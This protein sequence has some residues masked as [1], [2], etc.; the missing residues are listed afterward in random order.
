[1]NNQFIFLHFG[2]I[3]NKDG[4]LILVFQFFIVRKIILKISFF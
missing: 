4:I 3:K 2:K 1:M